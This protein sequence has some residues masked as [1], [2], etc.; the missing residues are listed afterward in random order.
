M[1][2]Y[3]ESYHTH[4]KGRAAGWWGYGIHPAHVDGKGALRNEYAFTVHGQPT[5]DSAVSTIRER[6]DNWMRKNHDDKP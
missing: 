5:L 3:T 4:A 2:T 6:L 1:S